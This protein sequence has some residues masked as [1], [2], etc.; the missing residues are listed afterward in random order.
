MIIIKQEI[1]NSLIGLSVLLLYLFSDFFSYIILSSF[2]INV[3]NFSK[4]QKIIYGLS[5][6]FI[7]ILIIAFIYRK[8]I[9]N[10]IINFKNC[11]FNNYIKYWFIS[12][13][14]MSISSIIINMFTHI[15]TSSNQEIIVNT[16]KKAPLYIVI[17]T[18]LFAPI[19]EELVFRLSFRKMFKTDIIFIILSGLFFGF[20]HVTDP[21]SLLEF[22]YI[23]P[24]SIP[25]LI[26]AYTLAKSDNICV[27]ITL[28]FMH[29]ALM[30]LIQFLTLI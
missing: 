16:F 15:E 9:K 24:Y 27:P 3:N 14:L 10:D 11:H 13:L 1:K 25:G 12:L 17:V 30:I 21:K 22:V 28:H 2:H 6:E 26:F 29:N 7:L 5:F 19:L 4:T 23:I 8:K 18:I 20:M